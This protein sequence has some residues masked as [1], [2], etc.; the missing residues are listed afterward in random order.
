MLTIIEVIIT[1][2]KGME[3]LPWSDPTELLPA[4]VTI[5]MIPLSFSIADGIAL[6]FVSYVTFKVVSG[7]HHE[8]T[9]GAWFL[10]AIFATKFAF[11]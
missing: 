9:G 7:K 10:T 5:I 1:A 6:G 2:I 4:L 11:S 3:N 8:V